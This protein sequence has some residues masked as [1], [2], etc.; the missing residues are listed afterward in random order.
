MGTLN[1]KTF[2]SGEFCHLN[3]FLL[4]AD[5]FLPAIYFRVCSRTSMEDLVM[6]VVMELME[7][8]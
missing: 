1:P 3:S 7:S 8:W 2:E 4:N 6:E 5:I